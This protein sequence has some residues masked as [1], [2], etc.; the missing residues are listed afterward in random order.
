MQDQRCAE[1]GFCV[2]GARRR[3]KVNFPE[4]I[5]DR[6]AHFNSLA[7]TSQPEKRKFCGAE[8]FAPTNAIELGT[9]LCKHVQHK[10]EADTTREGG[11]SDLGL[12]SPCTK[13]DNKREQPPASKAKSMFSDAVEKHPGPTGSWTPSDRTCQRSH[14]QLLGPA[15]Q[16]RRNCWDVVRSRHPQTSTS[17]VKRVLQGADKVGCDLACRGDY[18]GQIHHRPQALLG[19]FRYLCW[20]MSKR[21][22]R[23]VGPMFGPRERQWFLEQRSHLFLWAASL[24]PKHKVRPSGPSL[25]GSWTASAGRIVDR[26]S[27]P[28][29]GKPAI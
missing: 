15:E 23:Q 26:T 7:P 19:R 5:I 22:R 1:H 13:C 12:T 21:R 9:S 6:H 28:S 24:H 27:S 2:G 4:S 3:F 8:T 10:T 16:H 18:V 25:S 29:I 14:S 17:L 11:C 20:V